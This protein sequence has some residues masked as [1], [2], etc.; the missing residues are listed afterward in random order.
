M[1]DVINS[2]EFKERRKATNT[3]S[4]KVRCKFVC[5]QTWTVVKTE[6]YISFGIIGIT[7]TLLLLNIGSNFTMIAINDAFKN[8]SKTEWEHDAKAF[9]FWL[10]ILSTLVSFPS[11]IFF[12]YLTKYF[13]LPNLLFVSITLTLIS[14]AF[15]VMNL[16]KADNKFTATY[17]AM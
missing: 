2:K 5:K 1:K 7:L 13:A 9:Y 11:A 12:A 6:P 16:T 15:F 10:K 8:E 14:G 17:L 3:D 4:K